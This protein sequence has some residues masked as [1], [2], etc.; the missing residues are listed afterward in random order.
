MLWE[1]LEKDLRWIERF[2]GKRSFLSFFFFLIHLIAVLSSSEAIDKALVDGKQDLEMLK[3]QATIG[4][5]Y[6]AAMSVME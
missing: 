5:M 6:P 1:E 2:P 3:R 4:Q